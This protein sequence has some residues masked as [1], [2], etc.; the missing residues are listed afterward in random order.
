MMD[1]RQD[2]PYTVSLENPLLTFDLYSN[3]QIRMPQ[4]LICFVHGGAWRADDKKAHAALARRL[5]TLTNC[6]VAVPNYRLSHENQTGDD[7]VRHPLHAEDILH[8]LI[9]LLSWADQNCYDPT[10]LFLM[11]HSCSAHMLSCIFLD[12]S[13]VVPRLVPPPP[14]IQAVKGI[15]MTEGIYDIDRLLSRFPA[16]LEWFIAVSFGPHNSYSQF[17]V[18]G[19]APRN[20]DVH[21]L[22]VHSKGDTLVDRS[23]SD[24]MLEHLHTFGLTR[25]S[26]NMD[27][28]DVEH[29]AVLDSDRFLTLVAE[30]L[31]Q[32]LA[33][34]N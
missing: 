1:V 24:A 30:F 33:A 21:W 18:I 23:Q 2:I 15:I 26:Q 7:I 5:V 29:D 32:V 14:L 8:F 3:P 25:V 28:F 6:P 17:S 31:S 16:Y 11:G 9:F 20:P 13:V 27:D 19:C 4:P 22:I 10:K 12:T 34:E